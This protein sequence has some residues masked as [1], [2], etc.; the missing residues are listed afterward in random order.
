MDDQLVQDFNCYKHLPIEIIHIILLY[1]R[2]PQDAKLL[3]D[4]SHFYK[5]MTMITNNH[6][7]R[8]IVVRESMRGEDINWLENDIILY[9]NQYAPTC[10]GIQP[11]FK[12]II[13]RSYMV[14]K[15]SEF[16]FEKYIKS[17]KISPKT[18]LNILWGLFTIEERGEFIKTSG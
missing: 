16:T 7:K 8:W 1:L 18:R 4:I 14:K 6:Y 3:K 15:T 17:N 10:L 5:T 11:K 12:E 2:E 9:A 13:G